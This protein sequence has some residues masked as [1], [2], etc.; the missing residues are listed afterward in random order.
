MWA[1]SAAHARKQL[2]A[3]LTRLPA[4]YRDALLLVAWGT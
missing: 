2:A 1:A 4:A 3:T